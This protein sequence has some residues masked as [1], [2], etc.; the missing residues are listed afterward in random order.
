MLSK[1]EIAE[2]EDRFRTLLEQPAPEVQVKE[3]EK[4]E[5]DKDEMFK[6]IG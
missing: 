6:L 3:E 5:G 2:F 1:L 4:T